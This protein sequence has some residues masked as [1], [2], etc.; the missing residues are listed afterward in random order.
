MLN[1]TLQPNYGVVILEPDGPLSEHDFEHAAHII[2]PYIESSGPLKG[3]II[4]TET[5]P[6]W[7]SFSALINH[8]K[9]VKNHHE[10][11]CR[12]AIVTNSLAGNFV[13]ILAGHF[14]RA[15][16]MLFAYDEIDN[17]KYWILSAEN[18]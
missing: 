1:V 3:L 9:F 10:F 18:R 16:I 17:A 13:S 11:I 7:E 15:E 4:S 2:D 14:I 6:G 8:F 12:V 5:F